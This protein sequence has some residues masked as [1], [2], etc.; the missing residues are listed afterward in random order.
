MGHSGRNIHVWKTTEIDYLRVHASEG[1]GRISQDLGLTVAQVRKAAHRHRISLRTAGR[2][3]GLILG[4][5]RDLSLVNEMPAARD[6]VVSGRIKSSVIDARI[7]LESAPGVVELCPH[8]SQRP[9]TNSRSGLC[10]VCHRRALIQALQD[11]LADLEV[12]KQQQVVW[13]RKSRLTRQLEQGG[14]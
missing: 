6:L 3:C 14:V 8:C 11:E 7:Q 4:Q 9:V 12:K 10:R 5:P 2:R 13:Q 1:A